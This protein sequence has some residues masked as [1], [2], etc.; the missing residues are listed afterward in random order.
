METKAGERACFL[1]RDD[2]KN[3]KEKRAYRIRYDSKL[4]I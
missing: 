4:L 2:K 1:F 3:G